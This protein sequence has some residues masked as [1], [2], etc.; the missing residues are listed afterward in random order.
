[1][2]IMSSPI[3]SYQDQ[4]LVDFFKKGVVEAFE[5]LLTRHENK[6]FNLAFR[7]TRNKEDAEEVVQDVFTSIYRKIDSFEG[8]SAF[9]SWLYRIVVN[10][11]F[12]KLR[13]RKQ[14]IAISIEDLSSNLRNHY[15]ESNVSNFLQADSMSMNHELRALLQEAVMR[16][17]EEYR[18][19]YVLRDVDGLSN[20]ETAQILNLSIPA[21]KSRLHRARFMLRKKL[22]KYWEEYSGST[23]FVEMSEA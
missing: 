23:S 7:Y 18:S 17:P 20:Q 22:V 19:V 12:M 16:L 11:A 2:V 15:L 6:A 1:M 5:E 3:S 21:I 10:S 4:E 8:K 14:T 9:T 13:K